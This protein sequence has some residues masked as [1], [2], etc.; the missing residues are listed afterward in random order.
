MSARSPEDRLGNLEREM[1]HLRSAMGGIAS[2]EAFTTV[3]FFVFTGGK[4]PT[5]QTDGAIGFDAYARAIVDPAS[6]PSPDNPLRRSLGDFYK[7]H[8]NWRDD[9]DPQIMDWVVD[10]PNDDSKYSV[11]LPPGQRLMVGLGIA[12]RMEFPLLYWV[13]PRSGFAARG[14][15]V[16][17]SPG[18]VDPD[19]RGEAGALVENNSDTMFNISHEMRIVQLLFSIAMIPNLREVRAHT[20]LGETNRGAGGFGSTGKH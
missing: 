10:D 11:D 2:F 20:E 5:R 15:T 9:L 4:Q 18:T 6:K 3:D 7:R 19:Y 17:N 1:Q 14:I 8:R 16:A 12:T 13:A